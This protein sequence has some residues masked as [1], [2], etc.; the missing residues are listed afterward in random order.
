MNKPSI[1]SCLALSCAAVLQ[2]AAAQ[3]FFPDPRP[4]TV[5]QPCDA[6][7][8]IRTQRDP[9]ALTVGQAYTALG[10]N[11]PA[12]STHAF[13][14]FDGER[15][16]VAL[17]CGRYADDGPPSGGTDDEGGND[18]LP[19]FDDIDNPLPV[20]FGGRA[21]LTPPPPV[22]DAFDRAVNDLCGAP[23]HRVPRDAFR[24]LL[25]DHTE[26]LTAL[27]A[28]TGDRVFADRP[29]PTDEAAFLNDL[30]D[31]WFNIHAFDHIFCGEP[32]PGGQIGGL[33]FHGRYWQLQQDGL[34]CRL[35]NDQQAEVVPGAI[36][37]FGARMQVGGDSA[38]SPI[39][40]YGYTLSAMDI[41]KVA[42]RAFLENPTTNNQST[43]CLLDLSDDGKA[44]VTVFVR[45][46]NGIRTFY[47][48]ATPSASDPPCEHTLA[49]Q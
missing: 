35:S 5:T 37:T 20:G 38:Q 3:S 42:T 43:A 8:S 13:I 4:F 34:A 24:T 31:A 32:D 1:R 39:K 23:G 28:F 9:V 19:F 7:L 45:R 41:L 15:R 11:K 36:Y 27:R 12:G 48:D 17:N 29:A 47:P 26:V 46:A 14:E 16:W 30:A 40:G 33:H 2:T 49:V 10:E 18:C 21:D 6:T 22:L 44:F 25:R